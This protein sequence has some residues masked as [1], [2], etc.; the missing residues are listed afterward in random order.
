MNVLLIAPDFL[1]TIDS[2]PSSLRMRANVFGI[3]EADFF[4][5]RPIFVRHCVGMSLS[6]VGR[7]CVSPCAC[8]F[9]ARGDG[10]ERLGKD[11]SCRIAQRAL[12]G[13]EAIANEVLNIGEFAQGS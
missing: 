11:R 3:G 1:P 13:H 9:R 4:A 12:D 8:A 7:G 2:F 5:M 6:T 10:L